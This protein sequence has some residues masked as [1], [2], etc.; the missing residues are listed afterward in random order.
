VHEESKKR[1]GKDEDED[2]DN[3]LEMMNMEENGHTMMVRLVVV[4]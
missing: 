2:D 1:R 4:V 3:G